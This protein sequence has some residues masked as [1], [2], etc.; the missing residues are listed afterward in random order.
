MWKLVSRVCLNVPLVP[1]RP[2]APHV[3]LDSLD[4]SVAIICV[5]ALEDIGTMLAHV[6]PATITA[7]L[8]RLL[9]IHAP[10][11]VAVRKDSSTKLPNYVTVL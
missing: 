6:N 1:M 7:L 2:S 3:R 10:I 9:P 4:S 5:R 8:V 11:V